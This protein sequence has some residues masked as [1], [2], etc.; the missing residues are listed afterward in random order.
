M[1]R[2]LHNRPDPDIHHWPN[3]QLHATFSF[4]KNPYTET[5]GHVKS[6]EV[7]RVNITFH[8]C[9]D[10]RAASLAFAPR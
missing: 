4:G 2:R 3:L 9:L 8:S 5:W 7:M 6:H 1:A 10:V